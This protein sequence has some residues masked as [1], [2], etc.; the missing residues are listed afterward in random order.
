MSLFHDHEYNFDASPYLT[1][2][3]WEFRN[4]MRAGDEAIDFTLPT[5]D[6]G[7]VTLSDLRG[8]PVLIEFGSIT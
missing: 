5:L 1:D 7:S 4:I 3:H 6:G 8:K 2:P